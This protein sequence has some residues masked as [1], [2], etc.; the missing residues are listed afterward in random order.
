MQKNN[1]DGDGR[2][3]EQEA[4]LIDIYRDFPAYY[5]E[6]SPKD[7][8][9]FWMWLHTANQS[10]FEHLF[11]GFLVHDGVQQ[12]KIAVLEGANKFTLLRI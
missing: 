12:L 8:V 3:T 1:S 7:K 10:L 6:L 2:L 9:I 11:A 5:S 4:N